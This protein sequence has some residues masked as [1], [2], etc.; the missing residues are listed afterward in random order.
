M[1]RVHPV[2]RLPLIVSYGLARQLS[3]SIGAL[4][5][6]TPSVLAVLYI[7]AFGVDVPFW[8]QFEFVPVIDRYFTGTLSFRDLTVQHNEHRLLFP[9]ILM[10]FTAVATNYNVKAE[11]YLSW[12]CTCISAVLLARSFVGADPRSPAARSLLLFAP[13]AW[14]LF[15]LRQYEVFLWGWEVQISLAMAALVGC[16]VA[17]TR[18]SGLDRFFAIA[19]A[20][21][22]VASFS[23]ASGLL[24][25]LVGAG[26]LLLKRRLRRY[27]KSHW[28]M[29]LVWAGV[30]SVTYGAYLVGFKRPQAHADVRSIMGD[31]L[32]SIMYF[33]MALGGA[34]STNPSEAVLIGMVLLTGY[35]YVAWRE[36]SRPSD[37][38]SPIWLSLIGFSIA[39]SLLITFSRSGLADSALYSRY[40]AMTGLGVVGLYLFLVRRRNDPFRWYAAG[41][42][43]GL[44]GFALIGVTSYAWVFGGGLREARQVDVYRLL[45]H[46]YQSDKALDRLY[47]GNVP[48]VRAAAVTMEKRGLSVF[49]TA[50]WPG[51]PRNGQQFASVEIVP[52]PGV[53]TAPNVIV[54][55]ASML[56]TI[57]VSG[58]AI[59]RSA[60]RVARGVFVTIDDRIDIPTRYG[61]EHPGVAKAFGEE[62]RFSRFTAEFDSKLLSSEA[63]SLTLKVV[64]ADNS[65]YY[66][67]GPEQKLPLEVRRG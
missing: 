14:M 8:D 64:A 48:K 1:D 52:G 39:V 50:F 45:T 23:F 56:D 51:T 9:R 32:G 16:I 43:T 29:G 30:A 38:Q 5:A 62:F 37:D 19:V 65:G 24:V 26:V 55:D 58:W 66:P 15:S 28:R 21:A 41:A 18:S 34:A 33:L 47:G 53:V 46:R 61:L 31:P 20:C 13:S 7:H 17:L 12:A 22:F 6:V 44:F 60:G 4:I 63:H 42:V 25:W 40:T 27:A 10:L 57:S 59:D 11:M 49:A 35:A 54:I 67:P 3:R 2:A 36:L